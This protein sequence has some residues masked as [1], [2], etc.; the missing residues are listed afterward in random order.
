MKPILSAYRTSSSDESS[1]KGDGDEEFMKLFVKH[2]TDKNVCHLRH[3]CELNVVLYAC[4]CVCVLAWVCMCA[5][6][7]VCVCVRV[8][9]RVSE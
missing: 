1:R 5:C 6:V 2:I 3:I 9:V 8:C 4:V 7:C